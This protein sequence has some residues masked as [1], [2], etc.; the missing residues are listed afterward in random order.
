MYFEREKLDTGSAVSEFLLSIFAASAQE[1]IISLSNNMKVGRRMRSAAGIVQWTHV[2]GY[3][4]IEGGQWAIEPNEAEVVRR[5]FEEYA[6]GR[7]LPEICKGLEADGIPSTGNKSN[8]IATSVADMNR[9]GRQDRSALALV[10]D[11]V[12]LRSVFLIQL[13]DSTHKGINKTFGTWTD[14]YYQ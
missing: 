10:A 12:N 2:Y 7:S 13:Q 11:Y 1:E 5:I 3:R 6:S 4:C 14:M 9:V 8:W